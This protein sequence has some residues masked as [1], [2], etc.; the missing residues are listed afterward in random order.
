MPLRPAGTRRGKHPYS[1]TAITA[2]PSADGASQPV[3]TQIRDAVRIEVLAYLLERMR[4]GYQ[5]GSSRCVD[6]IEARR[7]SGR[8][9]DAHVNFVGTG[10]SHHANDFATSRPAHD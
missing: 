8:A 10:A 4:R 5:F 1:T 2:S 6:A 3:E 9:T 7:D